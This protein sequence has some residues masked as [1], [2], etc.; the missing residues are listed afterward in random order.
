MSV[1][2]WSL[3]SN[4]IMRS[5]PS[6]RRTQYSARRVRN[7][8]SACELLPLRLPLTD[9]KLHLADGLES[10]VVSGI[11]KRLNRLCIMQTW[12]HIGEGSESKREHTSPQANTFG[13]EVSQ[14]SFTEI[15][16]FPSTFNSFSAAHSSEF[17]TTPP[18]Q[19][20]ISGFSS[21]LLWN[22]YSLIDSWYIAHSVIHISVL[23][24]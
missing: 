7:T 18:A 9:H 15:P 3:R 6:S 12:A 22:T 21:L 23:N 5:L 11:E 14:A 24:N 19:M 4:P 13:T 10:T 16:P 2:K 1:R 8:C 20:T 17:A